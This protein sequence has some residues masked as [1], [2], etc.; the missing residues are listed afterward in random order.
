MAQALAELTDEHARVVL[1]PAF[2][3]AG[4]HVRTDL[5]AQLD[6]IGATA[7]VE[8]TPAL[9][10]D[11]ALVHA[12]A[13]RLRGAGWRPGDAVVLGAAGSSESRARAEVRDAARAMGRRLGT[14]VHVG[15][16]A[17]GGPR[18][19]D[20]VEQLG[21]RRRRVA[22]ASWLLA[23]GFFQDRLNSCAAQIRAPSLAGHR[24]VVDAVLARYRRACLMAAEAA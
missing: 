16:L 6:A 9:G 8:I 23:P 17:G 7:R 10:A 15:Y 5:P 20:V 21:S 19:A 13:Q 18:L 3:A 1:V 12:A 11:P 22:V 2:L 4:Y 24:G 14:P